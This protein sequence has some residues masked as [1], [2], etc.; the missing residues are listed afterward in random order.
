M[1]LETSKGFGPSKITE[2]SIFSDPLNIFESSEVDEDIVSGRSVVFRPLSE[3]NEGPYE[4]SLDPQGEQQY[5]Q[6][7]S[8]RLG[9]QC[10]ILRANGEDLKDIDDLSIVN[11]FP[12]SLFQ[13]IE[14]KFNNTII[15]DLTS[16][17]SHYQAYIQSICSYNTSSQKTHMQGQMLIPDDAG[18]FDYLTYDSTIIK[19]MDDRWNE[20][21][22]FQTFGPETRQAVLD[23]V[24]KT[25]SSE[26]ITVD[27]QGRFVMPKP[28]PTGSGSGS[29]GQSN[30]GGQGGQS[31]TESISST[32]TFDVTD[33]KEINKYTKKDAMKLIEQYIAVATNSSGVNSG[34]LN[35]RKIIAKSKMFDFYIPLCSDIFHSDKF[36]HPSISVKLLLRRSPDGFCLLSDSTNAFRIE[37]S[38]LKLHTRYVRINDAIV[39]KHKMLISSEKPM[40]YPITRTSMKSFNIPQNN[41]SMYISGMFSGILPK[42]III[43]MVLNEAFYGKQN[44]NPFNFQH[45]NLKSAHLRVNGEIVPSDPIS[46]DFNKNLFMREYLEFYRNIGIDISDASGNL[47]T[48]AQYKN[49]SFFMAFDLSGEQC[50][51]L[52]RHKTMTGNIDFEGN[53][54][55]ALPNTI[56]LVVFSS[57]DAEICI[58]P[59]GP[60]VDYRV[61]KSG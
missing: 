19:A 29:G 5:L 39:K 6:L 21:N 58:G 49:G 44:K 9:G 42:T 18:K 35:R 33:L 57:T 46:P 60:Y 48:P 23:S 2:S 13:G 17:L 22:I 30:Q 8:V 37:L 51:Q 24:N 43:G 4:F 55:V 25:E 7:N 10:R 32:L 28:K 11:M 34:Y 59:K 45:F 53:F 36:L 38:N 27:A 50:N 12:S 15:T 3:N 14:T 61:V 47:I 31:E 41:A 40:R 20:S 54:Q 16:N 26:S 52:H 56:T 1:D